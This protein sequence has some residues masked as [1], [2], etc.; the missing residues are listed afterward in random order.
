MFSINITNVNEKWPLSH[1]LFTRNEKYILS[2]RL[3][4]MAESSWECK[5]EKFNHFFACLYIHTKKCAKNTFGWGISLQT[6][7]IRSTPLPFFCVLHLSFACI[8]CQF[9]D[10]IIANYLNKLKFNKQ[11][12][13][14]TCVSAAVATKKAYWWDVIDW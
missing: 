11:N 3:W 10:N 14:Q 12:Q 2:I 9:N 1:R 5:I 4:I 8:S 13:A 7:W 6:N